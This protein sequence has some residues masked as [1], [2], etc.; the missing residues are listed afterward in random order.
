[1]AEKKTGITDP[2]QVLQECYLA[3]TEELAKR[4]KCTPEEAATEQ[5]F[6]AREALPYLEGEDAQRA[7]EAI[8]RAGAWSKDTAAP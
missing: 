3:D 1:M 7:R 8:S 2:L 5:A 4:L 6:A